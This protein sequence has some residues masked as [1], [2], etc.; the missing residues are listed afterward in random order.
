MHILE[1]NSDEIDYVAGGPF[2]VA[3]WAA[4]KAAKVSATIAAASFGVGGAA[5]IAALDNDD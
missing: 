4:F 3:F 2:F 5:A 1:L